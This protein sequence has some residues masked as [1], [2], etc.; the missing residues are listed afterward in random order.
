MGRR[1]LLFVGLCT[2]LILAE[3]AGASAIMDEIDATTL[4]EA[5]RLTAEWHGSGDPE[6]RGDAPPQ[7]P[8]IITGMALCYNTD[9][10][11]C[12]ADR[13][14]AATPG[15]PTITDIATFPVQVA[16]VHSQPNGWG[17][18]GRPTNFYTEGGV[19]EVTGTLLGQP[20]SVR[21]TPVWW[22]WDYGDGVTNSTDTGGERWSEEKRFRPAPTSHIYEEKADYT[23][24]T[25]IDYAAEY[26]IAD[27]PWIRVD[28]GL[29]VRANDL[30]IQTWHVKTV[31]VAHDCIEDPKGI[32]C[33]GTLER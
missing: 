30:V 33:P 31:L 10:A 23:V 16:T 17:V 7:V 14:P 19:H 24:T 20:A 28:G 5:V 29:R 26:K 8:E 4:A 25:Y 18:V 22:H 21:F 9:A 12:V 1:G 2:G 6:S 11:V 3:Q 27:G 15:S 32:G 13:A